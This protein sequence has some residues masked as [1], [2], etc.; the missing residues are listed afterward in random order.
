MPP[1]TRRFRRLQPGCDPTVADM[2]RHLLP[3]LRETA[4]AIE[5]DLGAGAASRR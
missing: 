1:P 3:A 2:K 5:R 4:G